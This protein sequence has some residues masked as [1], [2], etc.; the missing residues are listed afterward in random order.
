MTFLENKTK[1]QKGI[2]IFFILLI[3]SFL[4]QLIKY[5]EEHTESFFIECDNGS[6]EFFNNASEYSE[7]LFVCGKIKTKPITKD[8][9]Y[10][11]NLTSLKT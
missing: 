3:V 5:K 9:I 2:L 7:T 1:F 6:Y 11:F 8:E 10:L 4:F